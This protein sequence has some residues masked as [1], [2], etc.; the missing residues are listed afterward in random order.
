[1]L[2]LNIAQ[3]N[4]DGML[5]VGESRTGAVYGIF[6]SKGF[7]AGTVGNQFDSGY[8]AVTNIGRL[9]TIRTGSLG[10]FT[11]DNRVLSYD[12][13]K[14]TKLKI[15]KI[16]SDSMF[17]TLC[18]ASTERPKRSVSKPPKKLQAGDTP[19]RKIILKI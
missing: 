8:M 2:N 9:L 15:H 7:L 16:F 18:S 17:S 3:Q 6:K 19:I 4:F 11:G 14:L 13:S 5:A 10:Y 1:M 12:L